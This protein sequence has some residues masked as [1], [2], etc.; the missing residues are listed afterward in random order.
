VQQDFNIPSIG[1]KDSM[2][3][4]FENINVPPTLISF[5]VTTTAVNNVISPE[6]KQ[7]NSTIVLISPKV[8]NDKTIDPISLRTNFD[9]VYKNIVNKNIISAY[10]LKQ[11]GIA[12]GL[13]KMSFGNKIG[14]DFNNLKISELFEMNYGSL[15]V[16]I[17]Y[18]I[19]INK[20]LNGTNY[21]VIGKTI[22]EPLIKSKQLKINFRID[23]LIT[24][25]LSKLQNVFTYKTT[26]VNKNVSIKPYKNKITRY[27]KKKISHPLVVIPVFLGT[28]CEYDSERAFKKAGARVKQILIRN[29]NSKILLKSIKQ[30]ANAINKANIIMV[31]GGF[32]SGDEPDGSAKFIVNVFK[33]PLIKDA[34]MNLLNNRDGLMIGICNGFQALIKLGLLPYGKITKTTSNSPTLTFNKIHHHM[35]CMVNT[36]VISNK[37]P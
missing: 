13:T 10:S 21:K 7:V 27:S 33:N 34:T 5:A 37:S 29:L 20:I 19:N 4:S 14:V 35:S 17:P 25:S 15:I 6:F 31:P 1:G 11:F 12:E 8:N 24:L 26:N 18:G 36:K 32:S 16:E 22:N 30:L 23:E 9:I 3:G 2:S 28:N